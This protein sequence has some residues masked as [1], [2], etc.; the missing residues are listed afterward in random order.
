MP[1][2]GQDPAFHQ[3]HAGFDF[4]LVFR[5]ANPGWD[6]GHAVMAR[7]LGV[8]R[9]DIRFVTAALGDSRFQVIGYQN[10][11]ASAE[12]LKGPHM[13]A[14]P[15][16]QTLGFHRFRIGVVGGAQHRHENLHLTHLP[17]PGIG[18]GQGLTAEIDEQLLAGPMGLTHHQIASLPPGLVAVAEPGILKTFRVCRLVLLPQQ[19][20]GHALATQLGLHLWPIRNRA[21][22]TGNDRHW[23]EQA[24][25]Q[26]PL[27]QR[28]R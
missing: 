11:R 28:R 4:R 1:Q 15:V 9:L 13:G 17:S 18:D 3:Q 10:F 23:R 21:L 2:T 22:I 7:H 24:G 26:I 5:L 6:H 25:R 12:K 14:D 16:R 19:R 8:G 27:L 20:Q